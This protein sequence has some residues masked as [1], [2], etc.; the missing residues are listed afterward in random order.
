MLERRALVAARRAARAG[1]TR[2]PT[3]LVPYPRAKDGAQSVAE[4]M[5]IGIWG[6]RIVAAPKAMK[7]SRLA[8]SN[9]EVKAWTIGI[10]LI[11]AVVGFAFI[12]VQWTVIKVVV[13][14]GRDGLLSP[15]PNGRRR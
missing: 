2:H 12:A 6:T 3:D 13:A 7:L 8:L 14:V 5:K 11:R 1:A 10:G 4:R 15:R 9:T